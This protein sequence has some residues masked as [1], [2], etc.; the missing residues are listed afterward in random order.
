[1]R[2]N[3][4]VYDGLGLGGFVNDFKNDKADLPELSTET[5]LSKETESREDTNCPSWHKH[6][7]V[8]SYLLSNVNDTCSFLSEPTISAAI[9]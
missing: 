2:H 7:V 4:C 5:K 9:Q 6:L 3:V 8:R 1:M